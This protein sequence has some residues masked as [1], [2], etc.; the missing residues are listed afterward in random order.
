MDIK[1]NLALLSMR[2]DRIWKKTG[3]KITI[4]GS[5]VASFE[6]Q[7]E[8]RESYK[9]DPKV[10]EP[11]P[12][13]MI[14]IDGIGWDWSYMA[15]EDEASKNYALMADEEEVPTE[16]ALMTK[17]SL[18]SDN[19]NELEEVKKEKE[20]IDYK[21]ENFENASKDLNR[22]LGSQK[23]DKDMKGVGINEYFAVLPPH[24][25]IYLPLK[26]D[27]SWM[28]LPEFVDDTVTDYT[29][30]TPSIDVSK[31][32]T[33]EQERRWK[34]NHPSFFEQ[35]GSSGNVVPKPMI[36]FMKESGCLTAT[37]VSNTEN[38][39]KPTVKYPKM[40]RNTSQ[41]P[42]VRGNQRNW[43]N[44]KSQRLGKDFVMQNKACYNC[45]SFDHLKF[46]YNP[47][48][49]VDKGKTWTRVNH[50]Q[51]N[52]KYTST[53]KSMTPR[54]VLLKS[55]TKP[56]NRPFSTARPTLKSAQPK[57][58]SFVKIV[59]S[60]VK[61][62]FET[63]S[64]PKNK[65]CSPTVRPKIPTAGSKVPTAKPAVAADKRNKGKP[66]RFQDPEFP[67]IVYKVEKA[68]YRLHQ[69]PRDLYGTL[70]KYLLDNGF[71]RDIRAAKTP[72]DRKNPWRK[73]GTGKDVELHLYRSMIGSLMY[74]TTLFVSMLVSQG[75]GSEHPS[76]SHHTP[77]AQDESI[78]H[79]QIT[80]SPQ[81]SPITSPEPIPQSH[82]QT[83]SQEPT[84]P[85]Q[86]HSVIT[87]PR[88]IT[89]GTIRISQSKVPSP[90][91]NETVFPSGDVKYREAFPT[92]TSL[93]A[94]QD[95]ENIAKTYAIPHEALARVKTRIKT[96]KDNERRRE[97]LAQEDAPNTRGM[98]QGEDMLVGDTVK[99][100]DKSADKGS[101]DTDKMS[102]VLGSLGAANILASGGLRSVFTTAS[103]SV[104]TASI[105][106]SPV[107]ATASGSFPTDV[108]FTIASVATPTT[109]DKGKGKMT[110][111]EQPSKEEVLEQMSIQLARDLEA[112]FAQEYLIIKEQAERDYK[113]AKIHAERELKVMI[114]QLD[115]SNEMIAKYLNEYEKATVGLS[116]D[117][118]VELI[119]ELLITTE[120]INET[121]KELWVEIK[122]LYEPDSRDPLWAL[123]R[124]DLDKLWSLVKETCST[125]EV[126]NETA[127]ELWVEIKRL[128]EPDSRDPLWALQ[129]CS[130]EVMMLARCGGLDGGDEP[131]VMSVVVRG[132]VEM[133]MYGV[134]VLIEE[135]TCSCFYGFIDKGL[136]NLVI[137]DVRRHHFIREC[138]EKKLLSVDHIHTDDNVADL[139]TKPFDAGKFQYLVVEQA[140]RGSVKG[141]HLIYTTFTDPTDSHLVHKSC[142]H[143][144]LSVLKVHKKYEHNANFHQIVDFVEAS[145]LRRNLKLKDEAG[146]S[147]LPD[148]DLF[149]NLTLTG[150]NISP[151]QKFS[152]QKGQFSHQ[153]KYLIHTIMQCLSPKS[154]GFNEF[155]S[156]IATALVC[157]ATNRVYNF[158]K[159]IFDDEPA[160]PLGDDSQ[161]E[162]FPTVSGLEAEQD[163][164]NI[165][166]TSTLPSDSTPRVTSLAA[167]EGNMQHQLNELTN[168]CTRLQRQQTEMAS[169]ITAQDLEIASLKARIKMLEDRDRG[170]D[171]PSGE[172]ATI[173]G[174]SL[175]T[176]DEAGIERST[177]KGSNGTDEMVNV[178]TSL[179]AASI[180]TS[181]VQVCVPPAVEVA[182]V[183]IP[184]A[185][186]IPTVSVPT[187]SG[188]VPTAS[189][190]FTT[191][192]MAIPYSR[193]KGKEKM[194][195]SE[196]P[197]KKKLQEQMDMQMARHLEE[198]MERDV[199]RINEQIARDAEIARIHTEEELQILI[200]GLN[201]NN[202]TV[203]KYLQE[204]EQ[205]AE[206]LSIG[207]RMELINDLVKYQD[208]YA[209]TKHF[210]GMSLEEIREKFVP[211]W[212]QI[213]D[214]VPMGSKEEGE[215]MKRKGLIL[216]QETPKK[217]KTSEEVSK[218]DLNEMMHLVPV[219]ERIY[220]KIIRLGGSTAS[221][222][223]FVDILKHFD[224]EDLNQLW[225]LVKETL[226]IKQDT[227]IPT[228]SDE[229]PLPEDFSTACEE[230]FPLL[231]L[232]RATTIT[233]LDAQQDSSNMTKTQSKATLNKHTPQGE[234]S[235]SGP[236]YQETIRGA[237]AHIRSEGAL[238]LSIDPPLSIGYTVGSGEDM[239]EHD[240]KLTDLVPQ[241]PHDSPL[242]RGQIPGSDKGSMTLKELTDLC[243]TL[244]QKVFDLE[245]VKTDQTKDIS[246]LKKRI[247]MPEQRK[248]SRFSS[249][250]P[251]RAD[252]SKRNNL[253]RRKVSKQGRK[254]LKSGQMFQD[255]V[256]DMD[257]DTEI[258]VK[259]KE[260]STAEPKTP[261]TTINLFDDEDV[262][263]VDT[264]ITTLQPLP[265]IDPKERDLNEEAMTERERQEE[266]SKAALAEMY[267]EVQAQI[268]VDHELA[269][270]L[271]LE[272]QEKY[273]VKE[274][275]FEEIHK[276]YIK[277]Q[278]WVDA[279]VPIGSKEDEKRIRSRKKRVAGS[280]SKHKSPKRQKVNDQDCKES[281]EERRKC[282]KVVPDDDKAIDY[283]TL[284]V[285]SLIV[286]YESQVLG[287]NKAGD[288]H[289]YKLTRLDGSYRN[290]LTF[291]RMLEV[292]DRQDVLDL[293]KIILERF[294]AN[295]PKGY[296]LILWGDLK[297]LVESNDSSVSINMFVEKRYPLTKEILEK[298][299]SSRLE[300][301]TES[302]LALDLIKFIKLQIEEK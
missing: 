297:T 231:S 137:P 276:L 285:K 27:L 129:R 61:R 235:G 99:D 227:S 209:K 108:I 239:M 28:G 141:N 148:A 65:V 300:A 128:Y 275:S 5:D 47:D 279:F 204:Y 68:M 225:A 88:R 164:A 153:W 177:D 292:L 149:E 152:F 105:D 272:E 48:T 289:V 124:E 229:F 45:G 77:S 41:S 256:L 273:T 221:Y 211:V 112:K 257:V 200:D 143:V 66:L 222:Q 191:T 206:D 14:A 181:G 160:S 37:K 60:N 91:A 195:E 179:D 97:G 103:L 234:G 78:H 85:S 287:T 46:N 171:D 258:I 252:A 74:F 157:L 255:N 226:N 18:S 145:H 170:G 263:I 184:P 223:F 240:I 92:E 136:I 8:E 54:D 180:L 284:D 79:E 238:I 147:S 267:D 117:E 264:S 178:L 281:D 251:F 123:Q 132:G 265:T 302:T 220:W 26:K 9:K 21:I 55:G 86:S 163:R 51:Y 245:N 40:Y 173:K 294:L 75:K 260:D 52:M 50:T 230:R 106:I 237:M 36:K 268:D 20:S 299:L 165:I 6:N 218:E 250:H 290:F 38:A 215:R 139:L 146:I 254:N 17:S 131:A 208:N 125:T 203:A 13:A 64:T 111:L 190:I 19:K 210:K 53:H 130:D 288:I 301:E 90:R 172:D 176:E 10:E 119:N 82:E 217:V 269:I 25:Q 266:A 15:E 73:D 42:K 94:G 205:F 192:T 193:R 1:W 127:K 2:A 175:E 274:R 84:V 162:A 115:R 62:P 121:A 278:K 247:T 293:H 198:E 298:M 76:K 109:R 189:P 232:V 118:K 110:E 83:T 224:R 261:P 57:M 23:L 158:S 207:E 214:F 102:H 219:E 201:R 194:V 244:L 101:D 107:V 151:S 161:G 142:P 134:R 199:Q 167:D 70:S 11:A 39:R 243:T 31:S 236:G 249:F 35:G 113:I 29:R 12:K 216:E 43:N 96:L 7:K 168:L 253:G 114:A 242:S 280:R 59:H 93:D 196:T 183:S 233:G 104:A 30:P 213:E 185:G 126:I 155:S 72:M 120:V 144:Y 246:S 295:D 241:T 56:I 150:Y 3:K 98:D 116:Y 154:T 228:A 22:L 138:F 71:Q 156:N 187:S 100:S 259:D 166:K 34:R 262:T 159:M 49:W 24:A 89:K 133:M 87:T 188:V 186:E 296:D 169:K 248:S 67:H 95:R 80:Q 4:H 69:T 58:T 16:Y 33:K 135:I 32:V 122:R 270:R 202:E 271:T 197:K 286:D 212:K 283:E 282:L 140:M 182:T 63:K 277:E 44:Q 81:H 174:R 291:S